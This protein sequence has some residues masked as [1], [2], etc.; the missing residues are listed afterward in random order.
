MMREDIRLEL[1]SAPVLLRGLR[2]LIKCYVA[3]CGF[4]AERCDEVVLAV[5]EAC[6]NAIRHAYDG[7]P[8]RKLDLVLRANETRLE[9]ELVD[10][11]IPAPA[12]ALDPRVPVTPTLENLTPGGLGIQLIHTVFDEVEF[13]PGEERGNR[14]TMRLNRPAPAEG[15]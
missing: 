4:P 14:V 1:R 12:S 3:D 6:T 2:G 5:D 15:K 8:D 7:A 11:G 9:M 10:D 13:V